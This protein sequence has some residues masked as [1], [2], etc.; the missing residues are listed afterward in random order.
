MGILKSFLPGIGVGFL[1]F[2]LHFLGLHLLML[3][4]DF[5][6]SVLLGS[7]FCVG[8][9]GS[10]F[11]EGKFLRNFLLLIQ[12][13]IR[14]KGAVLCSFNAFNGAVMAVAIIDVKAACSC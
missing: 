13:T 14:I 1:G 3:G 5:V 7:S 8:S 11:L 2:L 9:G 4:M 6:S 12:E 10:I